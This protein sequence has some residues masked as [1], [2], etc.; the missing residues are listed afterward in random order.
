[1]VSIPQR[2]R[3]TFE[4]ASLV[5][6]PFGKHAGARLGDVP[7]RYLDWLVGEPLTRFPMI[8]EALEVYLAD[9]AIERM[10]RDEDWEDD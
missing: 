3:M 5:E 6:L 9:D 4:E 7:L 8:K 1:M 2:K 10:V